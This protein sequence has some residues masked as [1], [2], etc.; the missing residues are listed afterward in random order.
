MIFTYF[1]KSYFHLTKV[2]KS[3][4]RRMQYL[5][6]YPNRDINTHVIEK[7]TG[8]IFNDLALARRTVF[9]QIATVYNTLVLEIKSKFSGLQRKRFLEGEASSLP[10]LQNL[11]FF[12]IFKSS[13]NLNPTRHWSKIRNNFFIQTWRFICTLL[14]FSKETVFKTAILYVIVVRGLESR[15][16]LIKFLNNSLWFCNLALVW[17]K[18]CSLQFWNSFTRG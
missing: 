8:E 12:V 11:T 3:K 2:L 7:Y 16:T 9:L 17:I 18:T 10:A 15:L 1:V 6:P 14:P 13:L 5:N 4:P